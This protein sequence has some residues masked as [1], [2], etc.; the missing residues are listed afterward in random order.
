[1]MSLTNSRNVEYIYNITE[2]VQKANEFRKI[3]DFEEA[4]P[5]VRYL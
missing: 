4:F 5:F 1:M 3:G 2:Q